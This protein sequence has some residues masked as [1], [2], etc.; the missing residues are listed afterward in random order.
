MA[1]NALD[2]PHQPP[3]D[4]ELP[5][6]EAL[7]PAFRKVI[8]SPAAEDRNRVFGDPD[9]AEVPTMASLPPKEIDDDGPF[10]TSA[11][12]C[13]RSRAP[14]RRCMSTF[15]GPSYRSHSPH[16]YH[17]T[18]SRPGPRVPPKTAVAAT[19][20]G[21]QPPSSSSPA[22]SKPPAEPFAFSDA[23]A[24]DDLLFSFVNQC[25]LFTVA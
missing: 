25:E 3:F 17:A 5:V 7:H 15:R 22:K 18:R 14:I 24:D 2:I 9:V 21:A 4:F 13:S 16:A 12:S 1:P 8:Y 10:K 6:Y 20:P 19:P 11:K 23:L